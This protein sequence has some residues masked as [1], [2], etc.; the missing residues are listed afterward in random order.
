MIVTPTEQHQLASCQRFMLQYAMLQPAAD[1]RYIGWV[2]DDHLKMLVAFN[3]FMG[4]ACQIHVAMDP[5]YHYTPKA[6]LEQVFRYAFSPQGANRRVLIGVVNSLNRRSMVFCKHLGFKV[7]SAIPGA[8]DDGG[9]IVLFTMSR[10]D[11]RYIP[12]QEKE[13]HYEQIQVPGV[14]P[15]GLH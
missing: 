7:W 2:V 14:N 11:C 9:D 4:H 6:M 8:H 15:L 13:V 1:T 10:E 12:K 3:A 5:G